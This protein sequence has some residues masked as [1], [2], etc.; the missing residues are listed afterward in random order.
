MLADLGTEITILE[1]MNQL[2]PGADS[3]IAKTLKRSFK[4]RGITSIT[5][6]LV[7]GHSPHPN[8]TMVHLN[9]GTD[10]DVEMVIVCVGRRPYADH[11]GLEDTSIGVD[12]N[13]FVVVD[14][15]CRTAED[16]V[17]A[18][19]DLIATPQLAHVA[20]A[21]AMLAVRDMLGENP[22]PI[23]YHKVP[24]AIYCHPEVA[25]AGMTEEEARQAGHDVAVAK[26]RFAGNARAMIVN[27]TDGIVK[28]IAERRP[29]GSS[30][31]LLGVHLIGPW[32]T[33]QLSQGYL[34]VNWEATIDEIA[35]FIQPH[36][37]LSELF[38]EAVLDLAGR[39][40]HG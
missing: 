16:H 12:E 17:Y 32:A 19:G 3:D 7:T 1:S 8:G 40:L 39:A 5:G 38:G 27:E 23:D 21:E 35:E 25:F 18:V 34:A 33:E 13:G 20:F 9:E 36:P 22:T 10:I 29:D 37:T 2:I 28:V 26:H 6:G 30:G 11:L 31:Q 4:N 14:E 15:L 24:W